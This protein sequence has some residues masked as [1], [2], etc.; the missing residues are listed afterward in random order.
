MQIK[1]IRNRLR[2]KL[3]YIFDKNRSLL[4]NFKNLLNIFDNSLLI[5]LQNKFFVLKKFE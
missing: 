3:I 4:Y 2:N 1:Q 5:Y